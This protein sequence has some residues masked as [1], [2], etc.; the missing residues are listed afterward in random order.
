MY[1]CSAILASVTGKLADNLSHAIINNND[2]KIVESGG[3]AYLIM[4]DG[5]LHGDPNNGNLLRA[6]ADLY[7]SYIGIFVKDDDRERKLA[8]KALTYAFRAICLSNA[9]TCSMRELTYKEFCIVINSIS[10]KDISSLYT[11]GTAWASWIKAHSNDLVAVA[12]ISRVTAIMEHIIKLDE[13]YK[14]GNVHLYIGVL[15]MIF[16]P[17]LG[18]KPDVGRKHFERAI[19]IAHGKNLM[20]KVI[21]AR[22]YARPMFDRKLHDRLLSEVIEADPNI[23][24]FALI[25]T[26]A[27]KEASELLENADE[28]F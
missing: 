6:A 1:S 18:G 2:L 23:P 21:Y 19:E 22:E 16:P 9:K 26:L 8:D 3:T 28:Y 27:Q 4:I 13:S 11:L 25:N 5:L 20:A 17:I 14:D 7:T 10:D 15:S 24:E 12:E